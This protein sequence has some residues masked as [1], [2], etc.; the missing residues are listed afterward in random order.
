ME[1]LIDSVQQF[2][3]AL[4]NRNKNFKC[5]ITPIITE[6]LTGTAALPSVP[7]TAV[8]PQYITPQNFVLGDVNSGEKI[9]YYGLLTIGNNVNYASLLVGTTEFLRIT[10]NSQVV[11]YFTDVKYYDANDVLVASPQGHFRGYCLTLVNK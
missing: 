5:L 10:K 6:A 1:N 3:Q 2:A 4:E 7:V 11:E 8:Q 9:Y